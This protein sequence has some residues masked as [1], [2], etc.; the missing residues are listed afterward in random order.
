[1]VGN[2]ST[3]SSQE[4]NRMIIIFRKMI[5][6]SREPRVDIRAAEF[7]RRDIFARRG[8]DERRSAE[9]DRARAFDDDGFV[10]HRRDV[11]AARRAT[12]H[13]RRDLRDLFGRHAAPGCRRC[14]RND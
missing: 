5:G 12:A 10:A 6:H 11:R 1:M 8:F 7:L 4:F 13:H 9:E 3:I 14:D 2:V